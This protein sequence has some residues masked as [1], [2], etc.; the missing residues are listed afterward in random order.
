MRTLKTSFISV[1]LVTLAFC[2]GSAAARAESPDNPP[3]H[4]IH[5]TKSE[6][7]KQGC[8]NGMATVAFWSTDLVTN[9]RSCPLESQI[10]YSCGPYACDAGGN[11]CKSGCASN[12]DCTPGNFCN[13]GTCGQLVYTCEGSLVKGTDGSSSNCSPYICQAGRCRTSCGSVNDCASGFVCNPSQICE[14]PHP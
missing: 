2:V 6:I 1:F 5:F 12:A 7:C 14:Y 9:A 8:R 10:T 4:V 11:T 3:P 13:S